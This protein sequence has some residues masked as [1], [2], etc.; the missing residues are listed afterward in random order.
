M[1]IVD[2]LR[3]LRI[4]KPAKIAGVSVVR[5]GDDE[6]KVDDATYNAVG[7]ADW[8]TE[9]PTVDVT[10]TRI[11]FIL[12]TPLGSAVGAFRC[13]DKNQYAQLLDY[14]KSRGLYVW[15]GDVKTIDDREFICGP[16]WVDWSSIPEVKEARSSP[17]T[18]RC[19]SCAVSFK[20]KSGHTLHMK[21]KHGSV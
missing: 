7:L 5:L 8:L 16:Y 3:S 1:A 11:G 15:C 21:A 10:Y 9:R 6:F 18:F 12:R 13:K 19:K 14:A 20:S 2:R 17:V 4:G